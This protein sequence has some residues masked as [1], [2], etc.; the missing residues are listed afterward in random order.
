MTKIVLQKVDEMPNF[1]PTMASPRRVVL[2]KAIGFR[3]PDREFVDAFNNALEATGMTINDLCVAGL[4]EGLTLA[5]A[6]ILK[7]REHAVSVIRTQSG[8]GGKK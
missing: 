6:K 2:G 5:A 8:V 7:Q 1:Y 3:A 4:R